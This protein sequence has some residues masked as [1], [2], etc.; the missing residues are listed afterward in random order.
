MDKSQFLTAVRSAGAAESTREAEM[1]AMAVT[2][3]LAQLLSDPAERR[4]FIAQLPG[5]LKTPLREEPPA[6]LA[7]DR[8]ALIQH[9]A[10][11]LGTH[12]SRATQALHAVWK[13][14]RSAVSP[15]ELAA[16][17]RAV[18]SEIVAFLEAG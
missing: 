17:E 14:L 5:F 2:R 11:A 3:S 15:G 1:V 8:E 18:P 10:A 7:M 4:H 13:V 16:F 6:S 9:V 12:A